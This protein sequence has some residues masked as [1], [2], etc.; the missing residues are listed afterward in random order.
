MTNLNTTI[1]TQP[2]LP[3]QEAIKLLQEAITQKDWETLKPYPQLL[4]FY[5]S[6]YRDQVLEIAKWVSHF[7]SKN[8][9]WCIES[10]T[11]NNYLVEVEQ[12]MIDQEEIDQEEIE[13]PVSEHILTT[14]DQN[15]E[16]KVDGKLPDWTADD[17]PF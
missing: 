13:S 6:K 9:R 7:R 11:D 4:F 5:Q 10:C 3:R 2:R 14:Q 15:K 12:K 1:S 16:L 8:H 17:I